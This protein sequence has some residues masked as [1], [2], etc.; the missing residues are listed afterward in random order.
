MAFVVAGAAAVVAAGVSYV[1]QR[2][3]NQCAVKVPQVDPDTLSPPPAPGQHS[4]IDPLVE[5]PI[6][7][8]KKG[9]ASKVLPTIPEAFRSVAT[10]P[11]K[12]FPAF[13]LDDGQN[14]IVAWPTVISWAQYY[15]ETRRFAKALIQVGIKRA[16]GVAIIGFNHPCWFQAHMAT[17][18][19]GGLSAGTYPTNSP[20]ACKYVANDSRSIVAVC[21]TMANAQKYISKKAEMPQLKRVIVYLDSVPTEHEE[22]KSGYLVSYNDFVKLG[23]KVTD[24]DLDKV[25][26]TIKPSTPCSLIYTSGTTGDPKGVLLTNDACLYTCFTGLKGVNVPRDVDHHRSISYLPPSHIAAQLLDIYMPVYYMSEGVRWTVYLAR[27][28]VMKGSL[29]VTLKAVKPTLFF[30]VPRVWEK[31][32]E[33]IKAKAKEAPATGL[34][35]R[36][37]D[38]AKE[39]GLSNSLARQLGG[40]GVLCRGTHIAEKLIFSKVKAALGLDEC[41]RFY[42]GAAPTQRTTMEFLASIGIDLCEVFG[43]SEINVGW[44]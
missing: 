12:D 26:A 31:F 32:C 4:N 43:M 7:Y 28:D 27:P 13:K 16:D 30:G 24:E 35:K 5:L 22:A 44:S 38:W 9:T 17:L 19:V 40:N 3:E 36:L 23:E 18:L 41:M 1:V 34:K 11:N 15:Q 29:A 8:A 20:D 10:G 2:P 6:R 37:I 25:T 21:D 14:P 39:V 33:G 42:T